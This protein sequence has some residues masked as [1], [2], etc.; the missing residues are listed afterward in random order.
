MKMLLRLALRL[1][2]ILDMFGWG[3]YLKSIIRANSMDSSKSFALVVSVL[4]GAA[5]GVAVFFSIIW[6]VVSNGYIKTDLDSLG[7]FLLC[8]AGF[9]AG[10]GINKAMAER[11]RNKKRGDLPSPPDTNGDKKC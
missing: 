8:I 3:K 5:L 6:D 9:M 7:I 11:A 1:L 2:K 10:G 4:V